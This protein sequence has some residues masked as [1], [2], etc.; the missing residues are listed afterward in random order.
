MLRTVNLFDSFCKISADIE[1]GGPES[2]DEHVLSFRRTAIDGWGDERAAL[3]LRLALAY[4]GVQNFQSA[5]IWALRA[6]TDGPRADAMCLLGDIS[7]GIND[8]AGA[9]DW[10]LSAAAV[11]RSSRY[12]EKDLIEN[13]DVR[14]KAL[15][16]TLEEDARIPAR[17]IRLLDR[18]LPHVLV[19]FDNPRLVA[20][21]AG[22]SF[23]PIIDGGASGDPFI[24]AVLTA[25]KEYPRHS[26]LFLRK[27]IKPHTEE[28]ITALAEIPR[29]FIDP[30]VAFVAWKNTRVLPQNLA[31][32]VFVLLQAKTF[33]KIAAISL[34]ADTVQELAKSGI[35]SRWPKQRSCDTVFSIAMSDKLYATR[36]PSL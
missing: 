27:S 17:P 28:E 23:E 19:C 15:R 6:L 1:A 33:D 31:E 16:R 22:P 11:D 24:S 5:S 4:Y 21:W 34:T 8:L 20:K 3:A 2:F 36:V 35:L 13:R 14:I 10:Y 26:L 18:P 9:L 25:A 12:E 7:Q 30:D 29:V 32:N